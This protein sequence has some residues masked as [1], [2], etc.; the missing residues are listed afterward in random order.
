MIFPKHPDLDPKNQQDDIPEEYLEHSYACK[1]Q[2]TPNI[3]LKICEEITK[4]QNLIDEEKLNTNSKEQS[5]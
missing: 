3:L 1:S 4:E 5:R 2:K